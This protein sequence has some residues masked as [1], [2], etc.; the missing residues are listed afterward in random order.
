MKNA[1]PHGGLLSSNSGIVSSFIS[2]HRRFVP[3]AAVLVATLN[4]G[5]L[6]INPVFDASITN[7][8][9]A[10]LIINSFNQAAQYFQNTYSDPV[11]VNI[12][13]Y[14]GNQ[15]PFSGGSPIGGAASFGN[16]VTNFTYAQIMN[17]LTTDRKSADDTNA[18]AS[19]PGSNPL[20]FNFMLTTAQAKALGQTVTYSNSYLANRYGTQ[21]NPY[22]ATNNVDGWITFD[23]NTND[24]FFSAGGV[25]ATQD[26]FIGAAEHEISEVLG[27]VSNL[28]STN[29]DPYGTAFDL[30][31]YTGPNNLNYD[32]NGNNVWFSINKGTNLLAQFNSGAKGDLHDWST[33]TALSDPYDA[34]G[35]NGVVNAI[36]AV[37]TQ[38]LDVVGWDLKA[39]PEPGS[40]ALISA[41][42]LTPVLLRARRR[43]A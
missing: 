35:T 18:V 19:L 40:L 16:D 28:R 43:R 30:F 13:V 27:R 6:T 15:G 33:N 9:T 25:T 22:G 26:D 3:V 38:T 41:A 2:R 39:V 7:L 4:A 12:N 31:R 37:D 8:S 21:F 11:T 24:W 34:F 10:A 32:P 20:P 29:A 1:F 17:S 42:V 5:A 36:T 14:F 23:P